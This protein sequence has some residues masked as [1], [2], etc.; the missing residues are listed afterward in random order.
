MIRLGFDG[1]PT[2]EQ[3]LSWTQRDVV[4]FTP[5][6]VGRLQL[7]VN[8]GTGMVSGSCLDGNQQRRRISGVIFAPGNGAVGLV[9]GAGATGYFIL[10]AN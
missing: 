10:F 1:A 8:R 2:L 6:N 5:P 3:T 7:R 4:V 9:T